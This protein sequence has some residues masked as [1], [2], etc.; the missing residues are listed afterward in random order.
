MLTVYY[1]VLTE[2]KR[3]SNLMSIQLELK[4]DATWYTLDNCIF[5]T[6]GSVTYLIASEEL[7][8]MKNKLYNV[9]TN[10]GKGNATPNVPTIYNNNT[11]GCYQ[12]SK[13]FVIL[14]I[15]DDYNNIPL[16]TKDLEAMQICLS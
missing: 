4:P 15:H 11:W 5:I 3:K 9:I 13:Q 2:L 16:T 14:V 1:N 8:T 6:K 12:A 7:L 10:K